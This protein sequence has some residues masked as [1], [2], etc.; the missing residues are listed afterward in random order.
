MSN[1]TGFW[2]LQSSFWSVF[3]FHRNLVSPINCFSVQFRRGR[4]L[5]C[6][7]KELH[8]WDF[9]TKVFELI[10][11]YA[12]KEDD[13]RLFRLKRGNIHIF[14]Y[15]RVHKFHHRTMKGSRDVSD[16][17][18]LWLHDFPFLES[19]KNFIGIYIEGWTK[20]SGC[21]VAV[22]DISRPFN[23]EFFVSNGDTSFAD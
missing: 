23:P 1:W 4:L 22:T 5:V 17:C 9:L 18:S 11:K 19:R 13:F 6:L 14:I 15:L 3:M 8:R 10:T 7:K 12:L 2:W 16:Y 21:L 20:A